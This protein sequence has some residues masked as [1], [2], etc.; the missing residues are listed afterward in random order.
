MSP[1]NNKVPVRVSAGRYRYREFLAF[2]FILGIFAFFLLREIGNQSLGYPDADRILMDGVFLLDFMRDFPITRVYDYTIQYYAQYPALSIGYRPPF[3]PFVEA[4]FNGAF[5]I[6]MWSSRLALVAFAML[7]VGAWFLLVRRV[8]DTLTAFAA[9]LMLV[10]TPFVVEWGWYTMG[11]VPVLSM[12]MVTSYCFYRFTEVKTPGWL[13][14]SAILFSLT[15]WTKQTAVYLVFWYLLYLGVTGTFIETFRNRH[16]WFAMGVVLSVLAPLA[17]ITIWLGDQN[18]AQ[19][20]GS[21]G[22]VSQL[23]RLSWDNLTLHFVTLYRSHLTLPVLILSAIG[24]T[25]SLIRMDRRVLFFGLSIIATYAFFTYI[26]G[27]SGRYPI[28]WIPAFTVFAAL[29]V[30][31]LKNARNYRGVFLVL[32][33]LVSGYQVQKIYSSP[34]NYATGYDEAAAYVLGHSESP[35]VFFDGYNNGY[36]T[37]FMRAGDPQRSM[38]VLRG[39]KLLSSSSILATHWLDVHAQSEQDILSIFDNYGIQYVVVESNDTFSVSI[40]EKLREFL[41]TGPFQLEKEIA[42]QSSRS[43]LMDQRLLIYRYL[44]AKP[45]SADYLELRLPVVGQTLRV[46]VQNLRNAVRDNTGTE[47][48]PELHR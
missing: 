26:V 4:L 42:V 36:F 31:Y 30:V 37:Y 9:T 44:N 25:W 28:F 11:E 39:D 43:M 12:M 46:P 27:K 10:T 40:H 41:K 29:P 24:I 2:A 48:G 6:N 34:L 7:G 15:V 17:V 3:F 19:S 32:A 14:A 20:I 16:T 38:Y 35:T 21:G 13:Y 47:T 8:F 33:V 45:P 22:E 1:K 5:G 18:I 23:E